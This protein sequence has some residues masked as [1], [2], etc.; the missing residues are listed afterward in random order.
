MDKA[1]RLKNVQECT[2]TS[3]CVELSRTSG[4][5]LKP[6]ARLSITV[7]LPQLKSGQSISNWEVMEKLRA[8]I[9][10]EVFTVIQ[11]TKS[12]LEFLRFDAEIENK[13][14]LAQVISKIDQKGIKLSGFSELLKIRATEAK[15]PFPSRHDWDSFFRDAKHM[16]EMK[17]G[18]RPDT[19]HFQ[20][21]PCRWF[22]HVGRDN[23]NE[24]S[25][26][27]LSKVMASF[28]EVRAVDIPICDPYRKK[29]SSSIN[30]IKTFSFG[31]DLVFE[32]YVQF[33]EY[34]GF[35][36]CMHA[37]Q[38]KKLVFVEN[39]KA[40]S[41]NIKVDFDRTKHLSEYSIRKRQ[42]EREKL[43]SAEREQEE[44][45]RKKL[46]LEEM[47]REAERLRMEEEQRLKEERK[48]AKRREKEGRRK[49]REEKRRALRMEKAE[50]KLRREQEEEE[51]RIAK[52]I[53]LEERKLLIA[54]RKLESIRLLDE[55]FERIKVERQKKV[56]HQR[57]VE[58]FE[59]V[60]KENT[61]KMKE[62]KKKEMKEK[63]M[64]EKLALKERQLR[65]KLVKSYK[66][67]EED[68]M[69][70]QREK[71]RKAVQ[72]QVRV[73]S[74][75]SIRSL[76]SI[77]SATSVSDS[78]LSSDT[79]SDS[80]S[81]LMQSPDTKLTLGRMRMDHM[82]EEE[83]NDASHQ[84]QPPEGL[85]NY[86]PY[87]E[88]YGYQEGLGYPEDW[89]Y[90]EFYERGRGRGRGRWRFPRG[91]WR[92]R[93]F[94]DRGR[95]FRDRGRGYRGSWQGSGY[96]YDETKKPLETYKPK[97]TWYKK[98]EAGD[99]DS[100]Y[101]RSRSRSRSRRSFSRSRS[102]SRR[103]GSRGRSQ[104]RSKRTRS[105]SRSKSR[106]KSRRSRTRS[107]SRTKHS[108]SASRSKS[109]RSRSRSRKTRSRSK[110]SH[111][112][113]RSRSRSASQKHSR[114]RS[115]K[116]S[117]S[118]SRSK[119]RSRSH[120]RSKRRRHSSSEEHSS[121]SGSKRRYKHRSERRDDNKKNIEN[122]NYE[123]LRESDLELSSD[124]E[125]Q[126]SH[127]YYPDDE[128]EDDSY[129][130]DY[131]A[132]G[133]SWRGH[134]GYGRGSRGRRSRSWRG[135]GRGWNYSGYP[136]Y[137]EHDNWRHND[138]SAGDHYRDMYQRYFESLTDRE[139]AEKQNDEQNPV[140][141]ERSQPGY[142]D[143]K[144]KDRYQSRES[145]TGHRALS[146]E[147]KF[148]PEKPS[149][150]RSAAVEGRLY[151]AR[152][153]AEKLSS[154]SQRDE[155]NSKKH[156]FGKGFSEGNSV[157]D[158]SQM[159]RN[160]EDQDLSPRACSQENKK[161]EPSRFRNHRE[162]R[163]EDHRSRDSKDRGFEDNAGIDERWKTQVMRADL[164]RMKGSRKEVSVKDRLSFVKREPNVKRETNV[165]HS[166]Y[167][168]GYD[169]ARKPPRKNQND[170]RFNI[171]NRGHSEQ[172]KLKDRLDFNYGRE[173]QNERGG[174]IQPRRSDHA[175]E[176]RER[177]DVKVYDRDG[178]EERP[179][180]KSRLDFE[181]RSSRV[182]SES[183]CE[184]QNEKETRKK[185]EHSESSVR[186]GK[187]SYESERDTD[188][189]DDDDDESQ[190]KSHHRKQRKNG[191][192]KRDDRSSDRK[193]KRKKKK[194]KKDSRR[195]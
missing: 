191:K 83:L 89:N 157:N 155:L 64:Q 105:R 103:S 25:S 129:S 52:K 85:K 140:E 82:D 159:R 23:R 122:I 59:H 60:D 69:E 8:A 97:T 100:S 130:Y 94:R 81:S 84:A 173:R 158:K 26:Y 78:D 13:K 95:G 178:R 171:E 177:R 88:K 148:P 33:K 167:N 156:E 79:D 112:K 152:K 174:E 115:R 34:I 18:E 67:K 170:A 162:N 192:K 150:D 43:Q 74:G 80:S 190:H 121:R 166:K 104:S 77:S 50:E 21:L 32:A 107:H 98:G 3:D 41:A 181:K 183:D 40:Y 75:I 92:G 66:S 35:A 119:S 120:S 56:A 63:K 133:G 5:Y 4:L 126:Y 180:R 111:A 179:E 142:Q 161:Q 91:P 29:M 58:L 70:Q 160:Y 49:A 146:E 6:I 54:Q 188:D 96:G 118:R 184:S 141:E 24:P 136:D 106:S 20:D 109:N 46:E 147:R 185:R 176:L 143:L 37:L 163:A 71:V 31:Q 15:V 117:R 135:R 116:R 86:L 68:R 36:K 19:V 127:D 65:D 87:F 30:G 22:T 47:K 7:T 194:K 139:M 145:E 57:E 45:V 90:N 38:G 42:A 12:T 165:V 48:E 9:L 110:S 62:L 123:D 51:A 108:R 187:D 124:P 137:H 53:A 132:R 164:E 28:G 14:N 193:R 27:V 182:S 154:D 169:Y 76:S 186:K 39:D 61:K 128:R 153:S 16:N 114:S 113:S 93:G 151:F 172:T 44:K 195:D 73:Q 102:R 144:E 189:D 17:P 99:D 138:L 101:S 11:V 2:D 168:P 175:R 125:E 72:G 55:I 149:R 10:P 134:L 1:H 131:Y